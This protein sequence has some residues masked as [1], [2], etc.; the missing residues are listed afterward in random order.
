MFCRGVCRTFELVSDGFLLLVS[1]RRAFVSTPNVMMWCFATGEWLA[2]NK[3]VQQCVLSCLACCVAPS[4]LFHFLSTHPC[5]VRTTYIVYTY[6]ASSHLSAL[7]L[8]SY[9]SHIVESA[10]AT[11]GR[12]HKNKWLANRRKW[13]PS[14]TSDCCLRNN[15]EKWMEW[16]WKR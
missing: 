15:R 9:L 14:D 13:K 10:N 1:I 11:E 8:C 5:F 7:T 6:S 12:L 4:S 16:K 2:M 3:R